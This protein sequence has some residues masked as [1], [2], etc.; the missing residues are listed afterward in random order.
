[1]TREFPTNDL[2]KEVLGDKHPIALGWTLILETYNAGETYQ[3]YDG[4][5][6]LFIRPDTAIDREKYHMA[7]GRILSIGDAAFTGPNFLYW[8]VKPEIGDYVSYPKYEG[9]FKTR[10]HSESGK[11]VN[12]VEIH[13][14]KIGIIETNPQ[15]CSTHHFIGQ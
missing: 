8:K 1:M 10:I 9:S 2:I 13:D 15:L 11:E 3:S 12:T 14:L 5:N 7:V 6:S 4:N